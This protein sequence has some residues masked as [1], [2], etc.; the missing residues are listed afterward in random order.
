MFSHMRGYSLD[1]DESLFPDIGHIQPGSYRISA[2]DN[3]TLQRIVAVAEVH[4]SFNRSLKSSF[5]LSLLLRSATIVWIATL[6]TDHA[7][8]HQNETIARIQVHIL[9]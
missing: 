5:P 9:H 8:R 7:Q 4:L 2:V 1:S 6:F 3:K